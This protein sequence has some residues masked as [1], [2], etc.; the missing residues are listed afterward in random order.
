MLTYA[1]IVDSDT[2]SA[3]TYAALARAER[4][5]PVCVRD[6]AAALS[7]LLERGAPALLVVEAAA[8]H[9]DGFEI[10][11]RL[12]RTTGGAKTQVVVVS[13]DRDLRERADG[14]RNRLAIGAVLAKAASGTSARR[15]I[16][17]LISE[18]DARPPATNAPPTP[19][20]AALEPEEPEVEEPV[21]S[22]WLTA[23]R[24]H[25]GRPSARRRS[26]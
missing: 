2:V 1:L 15:V 6:G 12:R 8:A 20:V 3:S 16:Q 10:I 7:H 22:S 11:E 26:M 23:V 5:S 14:L 4:L 19:N 18:P 21:R 25:L 17:K 24:H 13:A 9:I